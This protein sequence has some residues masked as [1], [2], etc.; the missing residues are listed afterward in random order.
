[1]NHSINFSALLNDKQFEDITHLLATVNITSKQE[2]FNNSA[3][4]S[5]IDKLFSNTDYETKVTPDMIDYATFNKAN[6]FE[7]FEAVIVKKE[8]KYF[9]AIID[10]DSTDHV[11]TI[12]YDQNDSRRV[13]FHDKDNIGKLPIKIKLIDRENDLN[14]VKS[15]LRQA[16]PGQA[17]SKLALNLCTSARNNEFSP[18]ELVVVRDKAGNWIYGKVDK[19]DKECVCVITATKIG[20]STLNM[21][22][23]NA[24]GKLTTLVFVN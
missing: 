1:M 24:V 10:I 11:C 13:G 14:Y 5:E 16:Q 6:T 9:F 15:K 3:Y 21:L 23:I 18:G 2:S 8:D 22:D 20:S 4:Q 17:V 12:T 7:K 19:A